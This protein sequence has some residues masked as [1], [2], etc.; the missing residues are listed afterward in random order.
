VPRGAFERSTAHAAPSHR[1]RPAARAGHLLR[2]RK[3][4]VDALGHGEAEELRFAII[5]A[6]Q[7]SRLSADGLRVPKP[8]LPVLG[9]PLIARLLRL[10]GPGGASGV[11]VVVNEQWPEVR[12]FV[13]SLDLEV[14]VAVVARST[15]SSLH[16][17]VELAP[18]LAGEPFCL[19]TV[20]AVFLERELHA[21]LAR[22]GR[23]GPTSGLL[24]VTEF[25]HDEKP[26]GVRL[27]DGG[28]I[29]AFEDAPTSCRLITGGIYHFAPTVL[30]GMRRA[31]EAGVVSLRNALRFLLAEGHQLE[32][33]PFSQMVDVDRE[34][35]IP[36][37]E[38]LLAR[39][40]GGD[41][42]DGP[43]AS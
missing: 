3:Q 40:A 27:D 28:R 32:A 6:G 13:E 1:R 24:A 17:L 33:F 14:P 34:S 41:H 7:G 22:A 8:L 25:I 26:L 23:P 10:A 16:S 35:D 15:P 19:F 11:A 18:L 31:V 29:L 38:A 20:D 43:G 9:E 4:R 42:L 5:A 2:A 21:F 30:V 36:L 39:E 37:A 12:T